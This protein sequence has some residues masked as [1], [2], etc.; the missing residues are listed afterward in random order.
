MPRKKVS[1]NE[2]AE[3]IEKIKERNKRVETDKAWEVS[4]YRVVI[5]SLITYLYT[6]A[7]MRLVKIDNAALN[8]LITTGGY[9]LSTLSLS[10]MKRRWIRMRNEKNA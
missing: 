6:Y 8:A 7:F 2:L 10:F 5:L 9:V 1:I 3:E 4:N